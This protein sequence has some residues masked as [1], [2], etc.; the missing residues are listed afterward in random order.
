[1]LKYFT[2]FLHHKMFYALDNMVVTIT[3]MNVHGHITLGQLH[4]FIACIY[5]DIMCLSIYCNL[6]QK[7]HLWNASNS[8]N[9]C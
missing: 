4:R 2:D 1:M 7:Q 8:T 5:E 3:N 6:V 9:I